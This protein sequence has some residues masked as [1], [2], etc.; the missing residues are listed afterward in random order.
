[1][2]VKEFLDSLQ[3]R[4][5]RKTYRTGLNKFCEWYG[6]SAAEILE[7]RKDDL[8]Q[9]DGENLIDYR[10]RASR[11][12][13]EI[14]KFYKHQLSLGLKK[15]TA[16]SH[17]L[18]IRSLF[19]YYKMTVKIRNGMIKSIKTTRSFPLRIEHVRKMY[20]VADLRERY[21]L[22]MATD[23]GLRINDF[24]NIK[25]SD[26]PN[27]DQEPPISFDVMTEKEDVVAQGFLSQETVEILKLYLPT[28]KGK[29]PYLL[30]SWNGNNPVS[31]SW[32]GTLLKNLC[33][34]AGIDTNGKQFTFSCFRKMFLSSSIDSGVGLTA[35]KLMC[36]KTV[37]KADAT[38]LI[39]VHL[40]KKFIQ[41]KRFLIISKE[42]RVEVQKI[43]ELTK[44]INALQE[45][46]SN[47]KTINYVVSKKNS[48]LSETV[49]KLDS[50]INELSE[51]LESF[52]IYKGIF[53]DD[54][55]MEL[56]AKDLLVAGEIDRRDSLGQSYEKIKEDLRKEGIL[57]GYNFSSDR[58]QELAN[59]VNTVIGKMLL[60]DLARRRKAAKKK[61]SA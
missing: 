36:G 53:K 20:Q 42:P 21:I 13:K 33:D 12:E 5:T 18:G 24:L 48:E 32:L 6:K 8:T 26:L 61:E 7:Q 60:V 41:L 44:A 34:K 9:R 14:E 47:Q 27:L 3:S 22:C 39:T 15:N 29:N 11:F 55:E 45:D 16:R 57:T 46:V 10:N 4:N 23:L 49:K 56:F 40:R 37:P 59:K 30:P 25:K 54:R 28:L 31:D 17:T 43:E 50:Q 52:E 1:M 2:S 35:G 51:K 58:G 38:Y 19:D